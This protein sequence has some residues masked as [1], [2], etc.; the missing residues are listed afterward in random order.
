MTD[1][2]LVR[3]SSERQAVNAFRFGVL[4]DEMGTRMEGADF[5]RRA[6]SDAEDAYG[7]VFAAYSSG[8]VVGTVRVNVLADGPVAPHTDLLGVDGLMTRSGEV[9][10]TSRLI[11]A[12]DRRGGP[13]AVRLA[14]ACYQQA[15]SLGVEQDFILVRPNLESLYRRLGY[16]PTGQEL[17]HPEAGRVCLLRLELRDRAYLQSV[18][19]VFVSY[20]RDGRGGLAAATAGSEPA[21]FG[22]VERTR[23]RLLQRD[24]QDVLHGAK[25]P[26]RPRSPF[27]SRSSVAP[28]AVA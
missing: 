24:V 22:C 26:L 28:A 3:S 23:N 5:E 4:V 11:V 13:L 1:I 25:H 16:R 6:I 27:R 17:E 18:G 9:S 10:V 15:V 7:Y 21:A 20:H 19:S 14:Q 12:S 8:R 2:R